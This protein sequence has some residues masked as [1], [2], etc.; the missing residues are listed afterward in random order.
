MSLIDVTATVPTTP[1]FRKICAQIAED[2][3][4]TTYECSVVIC[5]D[6]LSRRM[7]KT[8]R[9][10]TYAPNVLSF[11]LSKK[12]GELFLNIR[13]SDKESKKYSHTISE[14]RVFLLIHGLLHLKGLD[15]G[16]TMENAERTLLKKYTNT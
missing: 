2:V 10:K 3:L 9:K 6:T 1:A 12:S 13:K 5:A 7:N 4:G 11:P 16:A 15:H 14:H 8:Y